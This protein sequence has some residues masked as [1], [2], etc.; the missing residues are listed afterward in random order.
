MFTSNSDVNYE[1][2]KKLDI[3]T[4]NRFCST[5]KNA[6]GMCN[7]QF[8]K[9]K[10]TYDNLPIYFDNN[11]IKGWV[12]LY[13]LTKQAKIEVRRLLIIKKISAEQTLFI[14]G[15]K[16]I[17]Y[18]LF[19]VKSEDQTNGLVEIINHDN[20]Y[21]A[22]IGNRSFIFSGDVLIIALMLIQF[23]VISD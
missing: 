19:G 14:K 18:S 22:T 7:K 11:S 10:F 5:N 1:I 6:I 20:D 21:G 12:K 13:I 15:K 17:L 3:K 8:W 4:L 9:E 23:M 2:L 16:N